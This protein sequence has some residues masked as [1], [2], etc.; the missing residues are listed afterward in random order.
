MSP[1]ARFLRPLRFRPLL[2]EPL[3]CRCLLAGNVTATFTDGNL[4]L[5]GDGKNNAVEVQ[6]VFGELVVRGLDNTRINGQE[7]VVFLGGS[8]LLHDLKAVLGKGHDRLFLFDLATAGH[9]QLG[10][11]Q[12]DTLFDAGNDLIVLDNVLVGGDLRVN[13]GGGADFVVL[14][15]VEVLGRAELR[16]GSGSDQLAIVD[17]AI[18]DLLLDAG[19]GNDQ[20]TIDSSL[21]GSGAD[22]RLGT[23]NDTLSIL[24]DTVFGRGAFINGNSGRDTLNLDDDATLIEFVSLLSLEIRQVV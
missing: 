12:V 3:E 17:S 6:G 15:D 14:N 10:Q 2:A 19:S 21:I 22:V 20:V 7:E 24:G 11:G 5:F 1:L 16:G 4:R 18:A 13:A 9:V 23:G 8:L